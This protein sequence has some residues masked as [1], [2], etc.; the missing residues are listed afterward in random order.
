MVINDNYRLAPWADALYACDTAWWEHHHGAADFTGQ[1]WTQSAEAA[2]RYGL[3]HIRGE[4][5]PGLSLEPGCIHLGIN[6]GYQALNLALHFGVRQI[7]LLGFDMKLSPDGKR[8]WFGDHPGALNKNSRYDLMMEHFA[9][10]L[11]D[12]KTAGV[13]VINCSRDTALACFPRLPLRD[14]LK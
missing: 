3:Q 5:K 9:T 1:K 8:H 2:A 4:Q 13:E 6:S 11:P 7:L 10:T 12:L 14:V